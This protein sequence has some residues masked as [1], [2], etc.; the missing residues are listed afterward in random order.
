[1][2]LPLVPAVDIVA[3]V[4]AYLQGTMVGSL[5]ATATSPQVWSDYAPDGV[6][7]PYAVATEGPEAY[8]YQSTDPET[9]HR[10]DCLAD[11]TIQVAFYATSKAQARALGREA[12]LKLSDSQAQLVASDGAVLSIFPLRA[13]SAVLGAEATSAPAAFVRIVTFQYKQEFGA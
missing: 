2:S 12:V 1:M 9:G 4:V 10:V 13:E 7:Y 8:S 5:G 11:G 6:P 3:A